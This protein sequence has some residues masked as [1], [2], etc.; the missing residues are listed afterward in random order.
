[1]P[2]LINILPVQLLSE[3]LGRNPTHLH[4]MSRP[5]PYR[6]HQHILNSKFKH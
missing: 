4:K 6:P 2:M 3:A 1:M 5:E